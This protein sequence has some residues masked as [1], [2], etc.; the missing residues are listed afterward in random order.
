MMNERIKELSNQA[1]DYASAKN[2]I[3]STQL[4][5]DY[6]EKFAELI[7]RECAHVGFNAAYPDKGVVVLT[8]IKEH[9]GLDQ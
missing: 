6:T 4:L 3:H 2:S 9:F 7:I 1:Y 5:R 8:A